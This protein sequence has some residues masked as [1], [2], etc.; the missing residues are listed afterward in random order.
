M[1]MP[2]LK[3][4][5]LSSLM[6]ALSFAQVH[7]FGEIKLE[8][9][10]KIVPNY[11]SVRIIKEK[12]QYFLD[13]RSHALLN[14]EGKQVSYNEADK[15]TKI[16]RRNI[17]MPVNI[18]VENK[19]GFGGT[20]QYLGFGDDDVKTGNFKNLRNQR[21]GDLLTTFEGSSTN[22]GITFIGG[23]YTSMTS[24]AGAV[25]KEGNG[26]IMM[27][28]PAGTPIGINL[29]IQRIHF[30]LTISSALKAVLVEYQLELT[31][32]ETIVLSKVKEVQSLDDVLQL[33]LL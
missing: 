25:L 6:T 4:I 32:K 14:A 19:S 10:K 23:G 11:Q 7:A 33:Q 30:D 17:K 27:I 13:Y 5:F 3:I 22:V 2:Q 31:G 12:N 8:D 15:N 29:G 1:K 28:G 18:K 24:A 26:S 20:I 21:L 9:A 16:F